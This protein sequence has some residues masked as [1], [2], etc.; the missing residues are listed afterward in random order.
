MADV[1][2]AIKEIVKKHIVK[3]EQRRLTIRNASGRTVVIAISSDPD[4]SIVEMVGVA[5]HLKVAI[6][7][8][9]GADVSNAHNRAGE[10]EKSHLKAKQKGYR[11]FS[12]II[13][14][15]GL[16]LA[17]LQRESQTTT[18]WFDAVE[19]LGRKGKD[20]NQFQERLAGAIGIP[21]H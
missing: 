2:I 6:E 13:S 10:A 19:A 5:E 7:V 4:V 20:W 18:M 11:D 21:L 12:T 8:K 14:K 17:K 15:K 3:E 9:G 1:F 16:A